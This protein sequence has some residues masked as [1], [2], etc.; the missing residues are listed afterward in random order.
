MANALSRLRP[1]QDRAIEALEWAKAKTAVHL[2]PGT[3]SWATLAAAARVCDD[4]EAFET[5]IQELTISTDS[6]LSLFEAGLSK[7]WP[8]YLAATALV[9]AGRLVEAT[10]IAE[11]L[12]HE[13]YAPAKRLR[14]E[15]RIAQRRQG[16]PSD[17]GSREPGDW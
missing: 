12:E 4:D 14:T 5:A 2:E 13:D 15:I 10:A 9:R 17:A 7:R 1:P 8:L 16:G 6:Q 3:A 11:Q